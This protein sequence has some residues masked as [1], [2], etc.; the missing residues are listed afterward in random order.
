[1][2]ICATK[3]DD[4]IENERFYVV[5]ARK[6]IIRKEKQCDVSGPV[7]ARFETFDVELNSSVNPVA[8][9]PSQQLCETHGSKGV[10]EQQ[11]ALE[12][13]DA[14]SSP[15]I[16]STAESYSAR[17]DDAVR[18]SDDIAAEGG[19]GITAIPQEAVADANDNSSP[20][21]SDESAAV[22]ET[23]EPQEND[24]ARKVLDLAYDHK[25]ARDGG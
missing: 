22:N 18:L 17:E 13:S 14:E 20:L 3:E 10:V 11:A 25:W 6:E 16:A 4:D 21:A 8:S 7:V 2:G 1:M 5:E 9:L 24:A 19:E 15:P 12:S 23:K